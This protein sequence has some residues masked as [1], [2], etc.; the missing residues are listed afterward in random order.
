MKIED[1]F[2]IDEPNIFIPWRIN[3]DELKALFSEK[4]SFSDQ[5]PLIYVTRG[6]YTTSC[7]SLGGLKH[8]LGFHFEPRKNGVLVE[9]EFFRKSYSDQKE[10][11]DDFQKYFEQNFGKPTAKSESDEWFPNYRWKLQKIE[12][13][14]CVFDRFGPEEHMR[15][16][17]K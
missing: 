5:N 9:L 12:I 16:K 2:Q 1:G 13:I 7:V 15:I 4:K 6:Y 17:L 8:K 14:H 11:F 10:S 3:E